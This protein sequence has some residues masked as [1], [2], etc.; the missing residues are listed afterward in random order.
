MFWISL[1]QILGSER[2]RFLLLL[3]LLL[4]S[5]LLL[6]LVVVLFLHLFIVSV[7]IMTDTI[8]HSFSNS[9]ALFCSVGDLLETPPVCKQFCLCKHLYVRHQYYNFFGGLEGRGGE[10]CR[11]GALA[12]NGLDKVKQVFCFIVC[13]RNNK[14][15]S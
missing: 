13:C 6:F 9:F 5:L 7:D 3:L 14:T 4:L 1:K 11:K 12:W 10:K 2:K 15:V 8:P